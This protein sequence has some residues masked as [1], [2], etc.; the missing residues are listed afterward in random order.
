[1]TTLQL[2]FIKVK[3]YLAQY[4]KD[5]CPLHLL[6]FCANSL[7]AKPFGLSWQVI[8]ECLGS[9][10]DFD[11][12]WR[13]CGCDEL[14]SSHVPIIIHEDAVPHFSGDLPCTRD[15]NLCF[16]FGVKPKEN[17]HPFGFLSIL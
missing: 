5:F 15:Q 17:K 6:E 11:A 3:T 8:T 2:F 1:M 9:R 12:L 16:G 4:E 10:E 7:L 13:A 14:V